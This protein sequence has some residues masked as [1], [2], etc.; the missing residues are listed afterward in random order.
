MGSYLK[1]ITILA[2]V[3]VMLS[4]IYTAFIPT[5]ALKTW[6]SETAPAKNELFEAVNDERLLANVAEIV[7][8]AKL[9]KAAQDWADK[10]AENDELK[11]NPSYLKDSGG[12]E[13]GWT[14]VAENVASGH[15]TAQ[16][17]MKSWM[18]S[19][20]HKSN[21]IGD[22]N[23]IGIGIAEADSGVKYFVQNFGKAEAGSAMAIDKIYTTATASPTPTLTVTPTPTQTEAPVELPKETSQA[24]EQDPAWISNTPVG[25][26]DTPA[27]KVPVSSIVGE[28]EKIS[29]T[30]DNRINVKGWAYEANN[31]N[32]LNVTVRIIGA[33]TAQDFSAGVRPVIAREDIKSKNKTVKTANVGF[34]WTTT[35]VLP[36]DVYTVEV[37]VEDSKTLQELRFKSEKIEIASEAAVAPTETSEKQLGVDSTEVMS[38]NPFF[39]FIKAHPWWFVAGGLSILILTSAAV[40]Q[41]ILQSR[42]AD[43]NKTIEPMH[44]KRSK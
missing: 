31:E 32:P 35:N 3:T 16:E 6:A 42:Q 10:L 40:I 39:A 5:V 9:D 33:S 8:S 20:A 11:H 30:R 4:L 44:E 14:S 37:I 13:Y 1:K 15:E 24:E 36:E 17:V 22:Y 28:V 23:R 34:D 19:P 12:W 27:N 26:G 38:G 43:K 41:I 25:S 21:I 2:A 7:P 18:G 29:L